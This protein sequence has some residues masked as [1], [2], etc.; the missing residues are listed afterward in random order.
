MNLSG[1][2]GHATIFSRMFTIACCLV[3][4]G[5]VRIRLW[6]VWLISGYAHVFVL[7]S[8]VIVTLPHVT[9]DIHTG[10]QI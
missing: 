7:L 9:I 2:V 10:K 1:H 5:R 8:I 6:S 4:G 3:L